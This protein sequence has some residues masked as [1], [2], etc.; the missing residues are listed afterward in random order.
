M[1]PEVA[2]QIYSEYKKLLIETTPVEDV[3]I[4]S[5][6][7]QGLGN[8]TSSTDDKQALEAIDL[9]NSLLAGNN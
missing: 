8:Y 4:R 7:Q 9:V 1:K 2:S 5:R 3:S 6:R